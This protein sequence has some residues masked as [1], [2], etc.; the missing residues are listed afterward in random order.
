MNSL[1]RRGCPPF[2]V[3]HLPAPSMH[4]LCIK[5]FPSNTVLDYPVTANHLLWRNFG[6]QQERQ[7]AESIS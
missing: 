1:W 5:A 2:Y 7:C 6:A 4:P 3:Q